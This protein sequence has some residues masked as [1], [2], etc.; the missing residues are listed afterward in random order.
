MKPR[1]QK[2]GDRN[3][4]GATVTRLRKEQDMSQ[5]LLTEQMQ[6]RGID[7]SYSGVSKLEG[8]TRLVADRELVALADIFNVDVKDLLVIPSDIYPF[9]MRSRP[10]DRP[11]R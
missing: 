8:Q 7:I 10:A 9:K 4:V 11:G 5:K 3:W 1:Q 2:L 6:I